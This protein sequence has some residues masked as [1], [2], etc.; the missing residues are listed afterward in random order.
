M[1]KTH[2]KVQDNPDY[3][4]AYSLL[5]T[6]TEEL[7]TTIESVVIE[8]LKTDRGEEPCRVAHLKGAKPIILNTTNSKMIEKIYGTPYVEDWVGKK[9]TIEVKRIKAFG[10]MVDCLRIKNKKHEKVLITLIKDS[11]EWKA[12]VAGIENG[13]SLAQIMSKYDINPKLQIEL[14][15]LIK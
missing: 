5:G 8:K 1:T 6:E 4:G 10:E 14:K 3:L 7:T 11:V 2:W 9:I 13:Y 12:V 15:K